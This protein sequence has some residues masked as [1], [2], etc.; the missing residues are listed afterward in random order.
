MCSQELDASKAHFLYMSKKHEAISGPT[1]ICG[2]HATRTTEQRIRQVKRTANN[3]TISD[4]WNHRM[5]WQ[6]HLNTQ[7][8][9]H[10]MPSSVSRTFSQGSRSVNWCYANTKCKTSIRW[11]TCKCC[12]VW[13]WSKPYGLPG[14]H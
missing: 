2:I 11:C 13:V 5:V 4:W 6:F 3:D 1:Y 8:K 12:M 9:W 14:S 7:T 10:C